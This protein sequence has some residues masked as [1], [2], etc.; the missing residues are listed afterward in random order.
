M[1]NERFFFERGDFGPGPR[2]H[3]GRHGFG[4]GPFGP[5][6]PRGRRRRGDVRVALLMLLSLESPLNGYQLMQG[7]EDRSE[8][9]WRPSPGSVYPALQ[10][11]EDEGLIHSVQTEGEAGR[12]FE[13][14]DAGRQQLAERGEQK[15]PWEPEEEEAGNPRARFR[16]SI[17][18]LV[19]TAA[20]VFQDG[21]PEQTEEA[22]KIL[23][24]ARRKLYRL[25]AGDE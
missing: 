10:Q 21:T 13:L 12:A 23:E 6:G 1:K 24:E 19:R 25:L 8:G 9:R 22:L 20:H 16:S 5:E 17:G 2:G 15:P 18:G 14:T 7:L 3:W 4:P 11:L